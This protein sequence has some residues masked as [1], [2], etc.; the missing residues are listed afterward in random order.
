MRRAAACSGEWDQHFSNASCCIYTL[1]CACITDCDI[2]TVVLAMFGKA[3]ISFAYSVVYVYASEIFP[4]EI[5]NVGVGTAAM[6]GR[7]SSMV[8]SYV[9]GPLVSMTARYTVLLSSKNL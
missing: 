3:F 9:G 8:A 4:T 1:V 6:C 7:V 2:A 5:R